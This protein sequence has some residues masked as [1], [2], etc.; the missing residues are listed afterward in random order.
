M[1]GPMQP[2]SPLQAA[3]LQPCLSD[4]PATYLVIVSVTVVLRDISLEVVPEMV[5]V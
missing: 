2:A 4:P 3:W 1:T 5:N